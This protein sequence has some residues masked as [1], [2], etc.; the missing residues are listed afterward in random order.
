MHIG[1]LQPSVFNLY[2]TRAN[3]EATEQ[4]RHLVKR[5]RELEST[6]ALRETEIASAALER[7]LFGP[8]LESL[9]ALPALISI[10]LPIVC[11]PN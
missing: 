2:S 8:S 10:R 11:L 7:V 6:L 3:E 5:L 1:A 9:L 4:G